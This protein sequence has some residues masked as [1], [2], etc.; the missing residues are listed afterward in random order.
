MNILVVG[1]H[2]EILKTVVGLINS[3][4]K[5]KGIGAI[6]DDDAIRAFED[7]AVDLVLFGG[8]VEE[9]SE[10]VLRERFLQKNANIKFIRHYGGG[11]GL[12]FGEI[13]EAMGKPSSI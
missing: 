10:H 5:W 11:S 12:L 8:G 9:A 7:N 4:P 3:E 13:Y 6:T 1:R 2:A